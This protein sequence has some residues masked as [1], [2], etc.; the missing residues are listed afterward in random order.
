MKQLQMHHDV[1]PR[2]QLLSELGD[3]SAIKLMTNQILVAVYVRPEK[4]KSGLYLSDHYRDEDKY[5]SKI[6]LLVS[7]GPKAFS[8]ESD[9]WFK[10]I[11]VNQG[12]WVLFR[13][14]D[15]WSVTVN[16]VPCKIMTDA[17]VRGTLDNPD[18]VW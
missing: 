2:E 11:S 8:A 7:T 6:G 18:R 13:P 17:Q 4:T 3:V 1:D 10:D 15:G 9:E 5:Q 14:S 16:G 12:D